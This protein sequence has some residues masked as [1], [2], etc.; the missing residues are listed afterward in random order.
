MKKIIFFALIVFSV[1]KLSAQEYTAGIGFRG[2]GELTEAGMLMTSNIDFK[3][4][5]EHDAANNKAIEGFVTVQKA[6]YTLTALLEIQNPFHVFRMRYSHMYW[7]YGFG[8]H[9]GTFSEEPYF[10]WKKKDYIGSG[11]N[12][13]VNAVL[14]FDYV[15]FDFPLS[16]G[17]DILPLY[18]FNYRFLKPGPSVFNMGF[19]VRY[20]FGK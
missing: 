6:G 20:V 13:G 11:I 12:V 19:S 14:G 4:N 7:Y 16:F 2:V 9:G 3:Y 1:V 15:F 18:D 10:E 5:L 8:L 17:L